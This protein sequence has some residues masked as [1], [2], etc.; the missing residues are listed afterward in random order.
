MTHLNEYHDLVVFGVFE[1][2]WNASFRNYPENVNPWTLLV[3]VYSVARLKSYTKPSYYVCTNLLYMY[4]YVH[5]S[6]A[7]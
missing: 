5:V 4:T 7:K 3:F 1:R 6:W 2:G